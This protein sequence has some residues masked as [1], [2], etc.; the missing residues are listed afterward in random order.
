MQQRL[1]DPRFLRKFCRF[2]AWPSRYLDRC[3]LIAT[4]H[5]TDAAGLTLVITNTLVALLSIAWSD[6]CATLL[7]GSSL[8]SP[9]DIEGL[10]ETL[11]IHVGRLLR[12][13]R[14]IDT[15]GRSTWRRTA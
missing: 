15:Q 9:A 1:D 11:T 13:H 2:V 7:P 10:E 12:K 4:D 5:A 8:L 3:Q 14:L 6:R